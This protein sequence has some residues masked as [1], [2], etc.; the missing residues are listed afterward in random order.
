MNERVSLSGPGSVS[1]DTIGGSPI[2][3]VIDRHRPVADPQCCASASSRRGSTTASSASTTS[4]RPTGGARA[5]KPGRKVR[6]RSCRARSSTSGCRSSRSTSRASAASRGKATVSTA[7]ATLELRG[8]R[9]RRP[10]HRRAR[11]P[12]RAGEHD[13]GRHVGDHAQHPRRAR[14]RA[15]EGTR[16]VARRALERRSAVE[17]TSAR[18]RATGRAVGRQRAL[19]EV[20]VDRAR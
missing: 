4:A 6:S 15:P 18:L 8:R 9:R 3:R 1:G 7:E 14:A 13:R 19:Q 16:H 10:A 5:P 11:V 20:G 17:L 2:Q 12:P